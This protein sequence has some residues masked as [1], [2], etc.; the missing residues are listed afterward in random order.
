M[1]A[2]DERERNSKGYRDLNLN[3]TSYLYQLCDFGQITSL[4]LGFFI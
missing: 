4:N 2:F 3:S 1:L